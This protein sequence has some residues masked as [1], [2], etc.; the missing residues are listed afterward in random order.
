MSEITVIDAARAVVVDR[1]PLDG[2]AGVF[3]AALSA[4]GRLGVVAEYHPK[5]LITLAHLEHGEGHLSIA[6][7]AINEMFDEL[8]SAGV[9]G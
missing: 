2:I 5:N 7:G 1:M 3:H 9:S 6:L 8:V 4:D